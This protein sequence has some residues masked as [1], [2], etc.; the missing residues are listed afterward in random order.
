MYAVFS[1]VLPFKVF[2]Q[3]QSKQEFHGCV[4]KVNL[5]LGRLLLYWHNHIFLNTY[6]LNTLKIGFCYDETT[7][8][9]PHLQTNLR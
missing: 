5:A 9:M 2:N 6:L 8:P 7:V 1:A 3:P 4:K